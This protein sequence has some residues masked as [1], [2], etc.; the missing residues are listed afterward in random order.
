MTFTFSKDQVDILKKIDFSEIAEPVVFGDNQTSVT[1]P[2]SKAGL[3]LTLISDE[4]DMH[5]FSA[6]QNEVLPY[7]RKLYA[8][9]DSAYDQI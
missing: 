7:G 3:F 6:D 1:V 9:Y 8:I 2:D 4:I 5:G